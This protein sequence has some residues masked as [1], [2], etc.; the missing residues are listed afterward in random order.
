MVEFISTQLE[1]DEVMHAYGAALRIRWPP[2]RQ[3]LQPDEDNVLQIDP[4]FLRTINQEDGWYLEPEFGQ[5]Y[6]HLMP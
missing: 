4:D 5:R 1:L 6:S 3:A 2:E